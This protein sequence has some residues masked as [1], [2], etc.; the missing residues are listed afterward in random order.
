[1]NEG[2]LQMFQMCCIPTLALC[3]IN[4]LSIGYIAGLFLPVEKGQTRVWVP[5][6]PMTARC[7]TDKKPRPQEVGD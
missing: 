4:L 7:S 1:M 2:W 5:G 6:Q 3:G